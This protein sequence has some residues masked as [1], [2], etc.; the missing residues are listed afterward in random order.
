MYIIELQAM[1]IVALNQLTI[2]INFRVTLNGTYL[3]LILWMGMALIIK[4]VMSTC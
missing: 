2:P 1:H 3:A 4:Y